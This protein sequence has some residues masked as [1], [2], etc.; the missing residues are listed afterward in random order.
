MNKYEKLELSN[1]GQLLVVSEEEAKTATALLMFKTGSKHETRE[2]NGIS[3]FLE[4]MFFKGSKKYPNTLALSSALDAL[5]CEFNAFTGK[6]YTGYYVK[7][8]A[9]KL[10][11]ALDVLGDMMLYPKLESKEIAREK[12]VIIE[13]LNMYQ[14]NP[15]MHIDD[16]LENCLYGDTPAGWDTIG[17]KDNIL[18]F[19]KSDFI[20]YLNSQY[21][22]ESA[23]LILAGAVSTKAIKQGKVMLGKFVKGNFKE[24]EKVDVGQTKPQLKVVFKDIDQTVLALA[25]RSFPAGHQEELSVKLLALVLGGA[26]SSR[27]FI[28]LRE[29]KGL[30]YSVRTSTESYSDS[31]Y[32]YTQAGVPYNKTEE[33]IKIILREYK[34][35]RTQLVSA[36]ELKKAKDILEGRVMMQMELSD[37][38]A[39]WYGRQ[40]VLYPKIK[41]PQEFLNQIKKITPASLRETARKIFLSDRLNLALIGKNKA[42]DLEGILK[43]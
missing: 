20:N 12:G 39:N 22:A 8:A 43:L 41:T 34:R 9:H 6:E 19:K 29:R 16:V 25:V 17:T 14:D 11:K 40:S 23:R 28:S 38:V 1:K 15:M 4:H 33:A 5:G 35:L 21:G 13:E 30:A 24:A 27:L 37:N 36:N 10:E 31:G 26:M 3:H 7:V 2:N 42:V 32:L 18:R